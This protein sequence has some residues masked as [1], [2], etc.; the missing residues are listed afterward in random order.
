MIFLL[1]FFS[2]KFN[3]IFGLKQ[4]I[5]LGKN[6]SNEILP[7][8]FK[9][10]TKKTKEESN[11]LENSFENK[12]TIKNSN[13]DYKKK[14]E[15]IQIE[16]RENINSKMSFISKRNRGRKPKLDGRLRK[17]NKF[18]DDNILQKIK[19]ICLNYFLKYINRKILDLFQKD[20]SDDLSDKK[21]YRLSKKQDEISE[22]ENNKSLLNKTMKIIFSQNISTKY[23]SLDSKHNK[24]LIE[25][26]LNVHDEKR[27]LFFQKIFDLSF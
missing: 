12:E 13:S 7:I 27:K 3:D 26:L 22:S 24:N 21:L 1:I 9:E 6:N 20:N 10:E 23:K 15:S 25:E 4:E 11:K 18:T 5:D 19:N 14:I 2:K 16:I 17:H 8:L